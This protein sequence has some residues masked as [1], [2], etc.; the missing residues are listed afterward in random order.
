MNRHRLLQIVAL[1]NLHPADKGENHLFDVT[2][3]PS[4]TMSFLSDEL[5]SFMYQTVGHMG[6]ALLAEAMELPLYRKTT[7]GITTQK[8][9][10]YEP[11]ENDEVEDLYALLKQV[12]V[13][14]QRSITFE[15]PLKSLSNRMKLTS[16]Q[17]L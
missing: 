9:K 13:S 4:Q 7:S 14:V 16:K 12:K 6:I 1:A 8:D 11:T 2:I 10:N 15:N 17:F 3:T 5:D